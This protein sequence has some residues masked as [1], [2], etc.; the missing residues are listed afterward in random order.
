MNKKNEPRTIGELIE[1]QRKNPESI[2]FKLD[3][4]R[5]CQ[6]PQACLLLQAIEELQ[7]TLVT[8]FENKPIVGTWIDNQE[9]MQALHISPRTLLSLRTN[10]TLPFSRIV[11]KIYY[12]TEDIHKIL[13]DNYLMAK[14]RNAE[15]NQCKSN[16]KTCTDE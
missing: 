16:P 5:K 15:K 13:N 10:G 12:R 4:R 7:N 11:N 14:C 1:E 8:A 6:C 2:L 9:V 3:Q